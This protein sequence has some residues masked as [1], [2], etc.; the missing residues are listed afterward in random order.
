MF[1]FNAKGQN[2]QKSLLFMEAG[3]IEILGGR[4]NYMSSIDTSGM[5][6]AKLTEE[7]FNQ[8]RKIEQSLNDASGNQQ[9]IYLLAVTR[10]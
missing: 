8:L 6:V 5:Q 4:C 1:I 10:H 7:Q 3:V 2:I 9:E